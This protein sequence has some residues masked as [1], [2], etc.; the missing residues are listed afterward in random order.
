MKLNDIQFCRT[1]AFFD[2]LDLTLAREGCRMPTDDEALPSLEKRKIEGGGE[3]DPIKEIQKGT[4]IN[5]SRYAQ[6]N[7]PDVNF[8][9][10][11]Y[12]YGVNALKY[13]DTAPE[14]QEEDT[15]REPSAAE[16]AAIGEVTITL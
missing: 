15:E 16:L 6:V 2:M 3:I 7:F 14:T 13:Q 11:E 4:C 12:M 10:W 5:A 9:P 1:I 8:E